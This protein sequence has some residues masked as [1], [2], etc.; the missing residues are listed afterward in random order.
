MASGAVKDRKVL[1]GLVPRPL[2][3]FS[4]LSCAKAASA[5]RWNLS[6][7]VKIFSIIKKNETT[8]SYLGCLHSRPY[9]FISDFMS[10]C[11]SGQTWQ[12]PYYRTDARYEGLISYLHFVGK[13]GDGSAECP[14][15]LTG[16]FQ[17]QVLPQCGH[18]VHEDAPEKVGLTCV[19]SVLW[20]L[21]KPQIVH[22]ISLK[23]Y[24]IC[25]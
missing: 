6:F 16:K 2:F 20:G 23:T 9:S 24:V 5:C 19:L 12:R 3:T 10:L 7:T 18:A 4:H 11:R 15:L 8:A 13:T 17:M 1:G 14:C 21:T 25:C 22:I